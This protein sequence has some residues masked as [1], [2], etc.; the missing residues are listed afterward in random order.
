[1]EGGKIYHKFPKTFLGADL[2]EGLQ[3]FPAV[4]ALE[5]L[6]VVLA[7]FLQTPQ[8]VNVTARTDDG[9]SRA[10][11]TGVTEACDV[12]KVGG[13]VRAIRSVFQLPSQL[14]L[15]LL[16]LRWRFGWGELVGWLSRTFTVGPCAWRHVLTVSP[17]LFP[18][19][20]RDKVALVTFARGRRQERA[21]RVVG[22]HGEVGA[23]RSGAGQLL[24]VWGWLG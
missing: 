23:N 18:F 5:T 1:M 13:Y 21:P 16:G 10:R 11:R 4:H 9:M 12:M 8:A 6:V 14:L 20:R 2:A 24:Q 17:L 7:E 19:C 15:L 22:V 3:N